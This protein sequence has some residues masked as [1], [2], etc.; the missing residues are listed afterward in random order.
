MKDGVCHHGRVGNRTREAAEGGRSAA[1]LLPCLPACCSMHCSL[2]HAKQPCH[3]ALSAQEAG[4]ANMRQKESSLM[5][6]QPLGLALLGC[7][8]TV[9][10]GRPAWA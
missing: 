4:C 7:E 1:E 10:P 5:N 2:R 3:V 9:G 6:L 8:P